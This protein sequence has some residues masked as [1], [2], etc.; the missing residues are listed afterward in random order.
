M[1]DPAFI[2]CCR[3]IQRVQC[4]GPACPRSRLPALIV[5]PNE[6]IAYDEG[7]QMHRQLAR[8]ELWTP[9][10][11]GHSVHIEI[12]EEFNRQVLQFLSTVDVL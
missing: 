10:E 4:F 5:T 7:R 11:V 12:P 9:E 2:G 1:P 6:G 3:A 8:S